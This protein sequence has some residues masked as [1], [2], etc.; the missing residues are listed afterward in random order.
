MGILDLLTPSKASKPEDKDPVDDKLKNE[1]PK[2][3][4]HCS[5]TVGDGTLVHHVILPDFEETPAMIGLA[6][7]LKEAPFHSM[8]ESMPPETL[9]KFISKTRD[10]V[11]ELQGRED[12]ESKA[13][14]LAL[15][16]KI[17]A[18]NSKD[19]DASDLTDS[20]DGSRKRKAEDGDGNQVPPN[21]PAP[22]A[23]ALPPA[24]A[25]APAPVPAP[26]PAPV[27]PP[28]A[29]VV[30]PL[31]RDPERFAVNIGIT[32]CDRIKANLSPASML[33]YS[34]LIGEWM[35]MFED[36]YKGYAGKP[37]QEQFQKLVKHFGPTMNN[38][39]ATGKYVLIHEI[40]E[41]FV[42]KHSAKHGGLTRIEF[43]C[44]KSYWEH[45]ATMSRQQSPFPA[46]RYI[47]HAAP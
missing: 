26:A 11:E 28:L 9:F 21:P 5:H 39:K 46:H 15:E 18:S 2:R 3:F 35:A 27:V 44:I 42:N 13:W 19:S 7:V 6:D 30:P 40:I 20:T 32:E 1:K 34:S 10:M 14:A 41:H 22:V 29:P 23:P 25:P 33:T 4:S 43:M 45:I 17:P 36:I 37:P 47:A 31:P 24:P 38:A 8:I 16:S 12:D